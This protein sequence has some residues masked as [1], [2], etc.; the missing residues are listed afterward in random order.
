M[1]TRQRRQNIVLLTDCLTDLTGGAERQIFELA[2]RINKAAY[3]LILASLECG[4]SAPPDI[5]EATGCRL[6]AF[7][8]KRIYGLSGILEGFRFARFLKKNNVDVLMTYHFSSDIWGTF[9]ARIAGVPVIIS[10]RRDI[11]FWRK[12][13]HVLAYRFVNRGVTRIVTNTQANKRLIIEQECLSEDKIQV[14]YNGVSQPVTSDQEP[15]TRDQ[16]DISEKDLAIMHVANIRPV[17][18]HQ[19]LLQAFAKIIPQYPHVKLVLIGEDRMGGQ[20]QE[21][22]KSLQIE[23]HVVFAGKQENVRELLGLAD[24]CVLPSLSEGMSNAILEYMIAG[25][26]VVATRVGGTPELVENGRNGLLV[27]KENIEQLANAL[28]S[29]I[30]DQEKRKQLGEKGREIAKEKFSMQTMVFNYER[31]FN[32]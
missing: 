7:P 11:G 17:K 14:I 24:I 25:K 20:M 26:P 5:A 12:K 3:Q 22:A 9:W 6:E 13:H 19:Y 23:N 21:L 8:V 30:H 27:E 31:I 32:R 18:G 4:G 10:N 16:F 1:G 15:A 29:L 28:L 2:K